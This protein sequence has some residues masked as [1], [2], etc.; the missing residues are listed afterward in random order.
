MKLAQDLYEHGHITY[1]RTDS[2][3]IAEDAK[4]IILAYIK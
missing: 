4:K 2:T 1:M 3:S